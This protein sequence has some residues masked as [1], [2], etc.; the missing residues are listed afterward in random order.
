MVEI[1]DHVEGQPVT[2]VGRGA[3]KGADQL[4]SIRIPRTVELIGAEAFAGCVSLVEV[5]LPSDLTVINRQAFEGCVSLRKVYLPYL[6]QQ[7]GRRAFADCSA[8]QELPHRVKVGPKDESIVSRMVE[9][10]LPVALQYIGESAFE[11]C[12]QLQK[13]VIP[14]Q[15]TVLNRS[16]CEGCVSLKSLWLHSAV[17]SI[18]DRAFAGCHALTEVKIPVTVTELRSQA[19]EPNTTLVAAEN[20]AA[21]QFAVEQGNPLRHG[22]LPDSPIVSQMGVTAGIPVE[23]ILHDAELLNGVLDRYEARPPMEPLDSPAGPPP[24]LKV[25]EP[26]LTY[27]DGVYHG[28]GSSPGEDLTI[29]MVGDLMCG[30]RMQRRSG[31][32]Q[33]GYEAALEP[34]REILQSA[35]LALGNLETMVSPAYPSAGKRTYVEDRPHLNA[36]VEYVAAVR[37]CGFDA[38]MNAQNHM[39]DTGA[40]GV[41]QTLEALNRVG[42][43]HGGLYASA[44]EPRYT[45]FRIKGYTIAV[46]AYLDPARQKMKQ[47]NL[48]PEGLQAVASRFEQER[49]EADIAAARQQGAEFVLAYAHWG[50]EYTERITRTQRR[51]AQMLVDAGADYVFGSHSHCPQRYERMRSSDGRDVPVVFSGGNF[52]SD[53]RRKK[54]IT[55]DTFIGTLTLG[56]SEDG[57][58]VITRDGYIPGRIVED[59]HPEAVVSVVPC[60]TLL[61][62]DGSYT[63]SDAREDIARIAR[64]M[65]PLYTPVTVDSLVQPDQVGGHT[66]LKLDDFPDT[67]TDA[68]PDPEVGAPN[69]YGENPLVHLDKEPLESALI[70]SEA[71]ARG[72]TVLRPTTTLLQVSDA[73]GKA[74]GFRKSGSSLNSMVAF[75]MCGDKAV[76]KTL[77]QA[78]GV[79]TAVGARMPSGGINSARRFVAEHGWPV[80]V[81][82]LRGS[83]GRGVTA[84]I[85]D[86]EQL[87][88]AI[89]EADSS[90]GFL[91]ET[92][93]PGEDYRFLVLGSEVV[94]AWRKDAANVVGD[95]TS[96]VDALIDEKN[97]LRAKNPHL[98]SRLIQKDSLVLNH[99]SRSGKDLDYVPE[100]GEKVYLRSAANLSSGGDHID[101]TDETHAS[102]KE[103]AVAAKQVIPGIELV[104]IDILMKDHRLSVEE[105]D[106]NV[107]EINSSPGVSAHDFPMYGPPR[108]VARGHLEFVAEATGLQLGSYQGT[109]RFRLTAFGKFSGSAYE[110][111]VREAAARVGAAVS[112]AALTSTSAEFTVEGSAVAAATLNS[113]SMRPPAKQARIQHTAL[114]TLHEVA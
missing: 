78:R 53:I 110:D 85:T 75:D 24:H 12:A 67:S 63:R 59:Y 90:R 71:L 11:N 80:V 6:L 73:S 101:I 40:L 58:A 43:V 64:V 22:A 33:A 57:R 105:Q 32:G 13:L 89:K 79:P 31:A 41:L 2:A 47:V 76:T 99:L 84:N 93:V 74:V 82:P 51:Y 106:V 86:E 69:D 68:V 92:H 9:T 20:S 62:D 55:Q 46:V 83:G 91:I 87:R 23:K 77:L 44:D 109:G 17:E 1:P 81:K 14:Y 42:L 5:D 15:V 70:E 18:R 102:V 95:G 10:S 108:S 54:P 114:E 72:L 4:R 60:E 21:A 100:A 19:F 34:V 112:S 39:Y 48:T 94:G 8:L 61:S 26:R 45:L 36:P 50:S 25:T 3:F 96:S 88:L 107:C 49:V 97:Q 113:L 29:A 30:S 7:I 28:S 66:E 103:V 38:V 52:L 16:V 37:N 98:A 35:D 27:R 65:G 56:R 111:F 104:G